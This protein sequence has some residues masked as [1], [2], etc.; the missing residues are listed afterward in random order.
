MLTLQKIEPCMLPIDGFVVILLCLTPDDSTCQWGKCLGSKGF[1]HSKNAPD[2]TYNK[3]TSHWRCYTQYLARMITSHILLSK[4]SYTW[5]E[6]QLKVADS[7]SVKPLS[8]WVLSQCIL[9][10]FCRD[11]KYIACQAREILRKQCL[12]VVERRVII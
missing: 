6:E 11:S 2:L 10:D 5:D 9:N 7:S 3:N 12:V 1:S 4:Q 8:C